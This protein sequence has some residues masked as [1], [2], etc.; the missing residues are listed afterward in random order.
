MEGGCA[1]KAVGRAVC[2][3]TALYLGGGG[4]CMNLYKQ[5]KATRCP[6]SPGFDEA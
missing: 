2:D 5:P 4:A 3:G 1:V 6:S